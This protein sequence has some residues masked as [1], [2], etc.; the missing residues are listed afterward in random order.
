MSAPVKPVRDDARAAAFRALLALERDDQARAPEVLT[1]ALARMS[2][3]PAAAPHAAKDRALATELVYGVLR[4]RQ[5][6]DAALAPHVS[7]GLASLEAAAQTWLRIGVYQMTMLDRIP[8]EIAVSATQ[9]AARATGYGRMTGLLNAVLRKVT[10][11]SQDALASLP[12]WVADELAKA[13][14]DRAASE[15]EALRTR[16]TTTLRPT[17]GKGGAA[18]ARVALEAA[19]LKV[20]DAPHG[21][22]SASG[23]DPFGTRGWQDGLFVAQDPAGAIVIDGL[24]E[25]YGAGARVLDLCAGRGIKATALADRGARVVAADVSPRKLD[26]L[27]A[28]AR[29]LGVSERIEQIVARDGTAPLDDLGTFDVVLVDAPCSGLGTLRRHPEIAWR[30]TPEDVSALVDLQRRL[31]ASATGAVRPGG[32][33]V[34]AVCSFVR[35]EGEAALSSAGFE[36]M[37]RRDVSPSSGLDGFQ[38]VRARRIA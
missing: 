18:A 1:Q 38:V 6:L 28:L 34:Y 25:A 37:E 4:W 26:E 24:V 3:G 20:E 27:R 7:R 17:L 12:R 14:G 35:V 2:H 21:Y 19:G 16:A 11:V 23:G 8:R 9:D 29:R 22:L 5:A 33:L 36:V 15:A 32:M 10:T 13:Y 30:R 31:V